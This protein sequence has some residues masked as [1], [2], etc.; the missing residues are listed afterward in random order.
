MGG[1]ATWLYMWGLCFLTLAGLG[2]IGAVLF[3]LGRKERGGR[4]TRL[5]QRDGPRE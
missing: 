1:G 2:G 4:A 3:F 5:A